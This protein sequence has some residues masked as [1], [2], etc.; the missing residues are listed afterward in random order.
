MAILRASE[1]RQKDEAELEA[2]LAELRKNL[3]K[4]RG[5]LASGG[6]P[7]DVGKAREIK[8]TIARILTINHEREIGLVRGEQ[9]KAAEKEK[10]AEPAV[11]EE[12]TKK[13]KG[14]TA[15]KVHKKEEEVTT[16]K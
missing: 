12:K 1:I 16:R 9:P 7:E 3:M 4:I 10:A 14:K 6:I 8:K 11:K 2:D 15:K 5:G 13:T